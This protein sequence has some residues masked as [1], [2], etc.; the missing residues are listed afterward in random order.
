MDAKR[1]RTQGQHLPHQSSD[2]AE[3]L[4]RL[5]LALQQT[6]A[7][8]TD[9]G[10]LGAVLDELSSLEQPAAAAAAPGAQ[11]LQTAVWEAAETLQVSLPPGLH[12]FPPRY[13]CAKRPDWTCTVPP[14]QP[15]PSPSRRRRQR[16]C[17]R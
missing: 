7:D 6:G 2:L 9:A 5:S 15:A 3:V 17:R 10:D 16:S 14:S 1:R 8:V 12:S 4:Q 13:L 11:P